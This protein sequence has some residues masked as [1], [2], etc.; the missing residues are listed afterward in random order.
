MNLH[1]LKEQVDE[2]V[3]RYEAHGKRPQDVRVVGAIQPTY[4]LAV[5]VGG[6][7][8]PLMSASPWNKSYLP[9]DGLCPEC[10]KEIGEMFATRWDD[11]NDR[12]YAVCADCHDTKDEEGNSVVWIATNSHPAGISPYASHRV[13]EEVDD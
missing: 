6:I 2:I 12:E 8:A 4:P 3:E 10:G 11:E 7:F 5:S 13:W 9:K 1:E